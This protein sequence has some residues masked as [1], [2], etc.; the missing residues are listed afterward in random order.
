MY[1]TWQT[2]HKQV[3]SYKGSCYERFNTSEEAKDDYSKFMLRAK[4]NIGIG[5]GAC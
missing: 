3:Y 5:K 1:D 4:S 2:Y